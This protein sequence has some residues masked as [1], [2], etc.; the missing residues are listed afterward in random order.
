M[1]P[2]SKTLLPRTSLSQCL[3]DS[4]RDAYSIMGDEFLCCRQLL[5]QPHRIPE[6]LATAMAFLKPIGNVFLGV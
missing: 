2:R 3:S 5:M 4:L 1:L 6:L